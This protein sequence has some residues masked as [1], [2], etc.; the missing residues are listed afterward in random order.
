MLQGKEKIGVLHYVR[1][2]DYDSYDIETNGWQWDMWLD[3]SVD[4]IK[5]QQMVIM[6][7]H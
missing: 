6:I 4:E 2:N 5:H 3:V 7:T 1:P